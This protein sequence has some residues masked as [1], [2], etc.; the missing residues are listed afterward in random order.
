MESLDSYRVNLKDVTSDVALYRWHVDDDFFSA[1]QGPDIQQG[2]LDVTLRVKRVSDVFCLTFGFEGWVCVVC[3]RCLKL[4]NQP[5]SAERELRVKFGE[6]YM[7]DGDVISVPYEE[8]F[9]VAW[10]LYELIALEIPIRHVHPEGE[11]CVSGSFSSE[12]VTADRD[13]AHDPRWDKLK[14]ILDNN[15]NI[16]ENGTS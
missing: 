12:S 1:V 5:V 9:N 3:D 6:E 2:Q 4:M 11:P 8:D 7:D 13:E 14:E 15:K 10:N 16:K